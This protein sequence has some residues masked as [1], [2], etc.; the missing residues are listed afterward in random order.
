M[1]DLIPQM[2]DGALVFS[3]QNDCRVRSHNCDHCYQVVINTHNWFRYAQIEYGIFDFVDEKDICPGFLD[4][5]LLLRKRLRFPFLFCGVVE[6]V[7]GTL[8]TVNYS[9]A[10]PIFA[11]PEDAV[12]ALRIQHPGTTEATIRIPITYGQPLMQAWRSGLCEALGLV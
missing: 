11:T 1:M 7:L 10:Y 9:S 8:E 5:L 4:E 12:R 6:R 2:V 3:L